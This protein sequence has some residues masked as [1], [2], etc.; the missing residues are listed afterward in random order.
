MKKISDIMMDITDN[1]HYQST[2]LTRHE[3]DIGHHDGY[4]R[5]HSLSVHT[6]HKV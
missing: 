1:T 6:T 3:E 5:Q 2:P 4:N